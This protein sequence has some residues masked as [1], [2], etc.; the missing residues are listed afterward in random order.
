ML[1]RVSIPVTTNCTLNCDKCLVCI[2]DMKRHANVPL[3]NLINDI[4]ALFSH[5]DYIYGIVLVGGEA[6]LYPDLD[7]IIKVFSDSQK[8][9]SI[10][11]QTNGTIIPDA[12]TLTAL[13]EAKVAVSI[14][15]YASALQ[16]DA[17][18]LKRIFQENGIHYTHA[19]AT[20][21]RDMGQLGQLQSGSEKKRF[22]VCVQQLCM[23]YFDGKLHLCGKSIVL[24]E[25]G[26][27][28]DCCEDYIDLRTIRPAMFS[29]QLRKLLKR[30]SILAC[31][32][33]LGNTYKTKKIPV[34]VQ[35]ES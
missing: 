35:R 20:F 15:K 6:F 3:E 26:I 23:P 11:V 7:K 10:S 16:P 32:Y 13:R 24:L 30:R 14:S 25:E 17:E 21:W 29:A 8:V 1:S 22:D 34:A 4:Q 33:C 28:S 9:G 18:R 12:G 5:V 31:R 27:I 19:S 2:P